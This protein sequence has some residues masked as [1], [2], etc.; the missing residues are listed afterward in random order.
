MERTALVE[1]DEEHRAWWRRWPWWRMM[2]STGLGVEDGLGG[3]WRGAQG[4]EVS[5]ALVENGEGY[6]AW[7]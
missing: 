1:N 6:R 5:T 4:L 7:R 2:R 3:E